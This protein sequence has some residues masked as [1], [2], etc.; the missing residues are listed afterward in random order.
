MTTK[1]RI[2]IDNLACKRQEMTKHRVQNALS[3]DLSLYRFK[4]GKLNISKMARCVGISRTTLEK[5]L[6]QKG[7]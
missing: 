4:S 7:L 3:F 5:Y 1:Q 6:W 2:H